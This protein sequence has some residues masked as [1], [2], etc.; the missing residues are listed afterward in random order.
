MMHYRYLFTKNYYKGST[1]ARMAHWWAILGLITKSLLLGRKEE[2][3]GYIHGLREFN[4]KKNDLL[5]R[6]TAHD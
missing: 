2:V 6:L 5:S 1:V 4:Q 3:R